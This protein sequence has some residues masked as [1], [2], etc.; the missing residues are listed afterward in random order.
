[1]GILLLVFVH[2]RVQNALSEVQDEIAAVGIMG[3]VVRR[4]QRLGPCAPA[5]PLRPLLSPRA[6]ATRA[7]S[8]FAATSTTGAPAAPAAAAV[9]APPHTRARRQLGLLCGDASR[10]PPRQRGGPERELSGNSREN[11]VSRG[12]GGGGHQ[13]VRRSAA[14]ALNCNVWQSTAFVPSHAALPRA[15]T[16]SWRAPEVCWTTTWWCG[17]GT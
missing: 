2:E 12:G 5:H 3:V 6:R 13:G 10:R 9:A 4:R 7:A 17:P 14:A 1:M 16:A 11:G 15:G 8:L